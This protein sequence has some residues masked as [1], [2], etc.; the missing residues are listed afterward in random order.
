V[1]DLENHP[2]RID[3]TFMVYQIEGPGLSGFLDLPAKI[4]AFVEGG[5]DAGGA[6]GEHRLGQ[7]QEL[8][9]RCQRPGGEDVDRRS[10]IAEDRLDPPVMDG[11]RQLGF[12]RDAAEEG[13]LPGIALDE[14]DVGTRPAGN[15]VRASGKSGTS[16]AL[17]ATWRR[18]SVPSVD[19]ATRFSAGCHLRRSAT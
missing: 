14:M 13:A 8:R 12:A 5:A 16:W 3:S 1:R 15:Q 6:S 17:S 4:P 9:E 11:D 19:G 10:P 7:A 18:Q 2:V